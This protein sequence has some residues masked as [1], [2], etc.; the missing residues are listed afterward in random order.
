MGALD[1]ASTP[2]V[3]V[4]Y[5]DGQFDHTLL[6]R[7]NDGN[8]DPG[9][10][11]D[12]V[13]ALFLAIADSWYTITVSGARAAGQSNHNSFPISW[14]GLASYGSETMPKV[15]APRQMCL[16]GRTL[17]GRRLRYFL[18]GYKGTS[19]DTYRMA[20][21]TDNTVDDALDVIEANQATGIFICIDGSVP[22]MYPYADFNFN[23]YY[24]AKARE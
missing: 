3:W 4:D 19:P 20:R 15:F 22:T 11:M 21:V 1:V 12:A 18:F 23:N 24:E 13:D 16:L 5:S 6:V 7:Y 8:A 10:V 9:T 17:N 2:R 14:T